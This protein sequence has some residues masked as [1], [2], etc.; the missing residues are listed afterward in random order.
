MIGEVEEFDYRRDFCKRAERVLG[1]RPGE[2]PSRGHVRNLGTS[3]STAQWHQNQRQSEMTTP[4]M[5][6]NAR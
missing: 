4:L 3:S 1:R 2:G 6:V 5:S